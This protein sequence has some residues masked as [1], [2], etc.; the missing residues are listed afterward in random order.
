M[1][2][3]PDYTQGEEKYIEESTNEAMDWRDKGAVT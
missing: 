3:L 1:T 2:G